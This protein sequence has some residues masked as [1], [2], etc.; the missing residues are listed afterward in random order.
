[1]NK[2]K[3]IIA[4]LLSVIMSFG[5]VSVAAVAADDETYYD[6]TF[7][8]LPYDISPFRDDYIADYMG[9][10]YGTDYWFTITNKYDSE[11]IIDGVSHSVAAGT[12]TDIK[13]APSSIK[14]KEGDTL[15]FTVSVAD[16]I[17]PQSVKVIAY[18][19]GTA[20]DELTD[21]DPYSTQTAE[22]GQPYDQYYLDKSSVGTYGVKPDKNITIN[23]SEY[24]LYNDC[25]LY[26]FPTSDYYTANRVIYNAKGATPQEMYA[27][28]E[29]GNT[30]VVYVNET[31]YFEVRLAFDSEYDLHYD[32]Y[33]VYY[34]VDELGALVGELSGTEKVYIDPVYH[35]ETEEE[36]VDVYAIE[37]V[38]PDVEIKITNTVTYTISMLAELLEDF[39]LD[40]LSEIDLSAID[41]SP[42]LE[43]LLRIV[44]LVV[45]MLN[46]FGLNV[47]IG[48]LLG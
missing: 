30:R 39:S 43:L 37:N 22:P 14:V 47:S 5:I 46:G 36:W 42:M 45:K 26:E 7:A 13:G 29:W 9:Y 40:S 44:N 16:Y 11:I 1:M 4:V 23:V 17:E 12:T 27:T 41:M 3:K 18:A 48:D 31:L 19:T 25:F 6:V 32:T 10:E 38:S 20:A 35:Y 28:S 8:D 33:E 24:H 2:M 15:E 21:L 34:M